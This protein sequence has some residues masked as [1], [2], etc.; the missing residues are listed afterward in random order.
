MLTI[1]IEG[2]V[3]QVSWNWVIAVAD[4]NGLD[5]D[6]LYHQG[7]DDAILDA[8]IEQTGWTLIAVSSHTNI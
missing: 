3:H 4:D 6:M 8:L 1:S 5:T 2:Q 7:G